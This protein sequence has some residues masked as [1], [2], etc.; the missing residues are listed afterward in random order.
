MYLLIIMGIL[1]AL[2]GLFIRQVGSGTWFWFVWEV[3]GVCFFCWALLVRSGFFEVHKR[4]GMMFYL[5]VLAAVVMLGTFCVMIVS[6]F[7]SAGEANLDYIIVLGAQV[8]EDGVSK[9]LKYRLDTAREYLDKNPDTICIVSGGQGANEPCPEAEVMAD[10]LISHGI[11]KDR[12]LVENQSM[13]TVENIRNSRKFMEEGYEGVGIVTNNFHVYRS[14]QIAKEQ[15]LEGV[16]GI[17]ADCNVWYLPNNILRECGS[18]LKFFV[19][20]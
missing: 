12:I 6:G 4:I 11:E 14:V 19:T 16:C 17:A 1:S 2:Y 20:K 3:I 8:R 5:L 18:I 10:Y 9:V 13:N 7:S 15:G